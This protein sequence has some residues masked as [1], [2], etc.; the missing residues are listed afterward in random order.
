MSVSLIY[1]RV[2]DR[3]CQ[4]LG[5]GQRCCT[6]DGQRE[7]K[8]EVVGGQRLMRINDNIQTSIEYRSCL[9]FKRFYAA[10]LA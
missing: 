5:L 2:K 3:E 6:L 4:R 7:G 10:G 9:L 1:L 8:L